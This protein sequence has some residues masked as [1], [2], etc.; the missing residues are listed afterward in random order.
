MVNHRRQAGNS[1]CGDVKGTRR[2][3][4]QSN[5][6]GFTLVELLVVIAIIG[7]LVALLLPAVQ[8]AREAARRMECSN[9][10]RQV[11][12]AMHNY[13]NAHGTFP[14]GAYGCCWG[15]WIE[16]ILPHL[17]QQ[18]I[19]D[20]YVDENKYDNPDSSYRYSGSQNRQ[21]TTL[22]IGI[23][24][25]PSD[26]SS[27][28][29]LGGFQNITSHN[30]AVNLGNTGYLAGY[31]DNED[32]V[33]GYNGVKF[34]GAP[35]SLKAGPSTEPYAATIADI[36]DGASNTL[37]ASEVLQGRGNDLRGFSWW[38]YAAG[39]NTY[40]S[41]N[42]SQPDVMQSSGYCVND[43]VNPPCVGPHSTS[44]PMT[45][46]ARSNHTGGVLTVFCDGSVH[47]IGDNIDIDTYRALSTTRGQEV[48]DASAY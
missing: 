23:L 4:A 3:N 13:E 39:F 35:F 20:R 17:E 31:P 42:S 30:Y 25:C 36:R 38:G 24:V 8:A 2:M 29:T 26:T 12:L 7:I 47:F 46:A 43:G 41:P 14:V 33:D 48:I 34:G 27:A 44:Q 45:N 10:L 40:L 1:R 9:N 6:R 19:S 32:A 15:T 16:A 21:V 22:Q 5:T 28:T 37:L 18:N 11:G